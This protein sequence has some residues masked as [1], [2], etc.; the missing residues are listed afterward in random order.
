MKRGTD[1]GDPTTR[2]THGGTDAMRRGSFDNQGDGWG[3]N[4][5]GRC[6]GDDDEND[7][8]E[9]DDSDDEDEDDDDDGDVDDGHDVE[10]DHMSSS[11]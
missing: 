6:D 10:D 5:G 1:G 11:K 4:E 2:R 3:T 8:G 9:H 7:D